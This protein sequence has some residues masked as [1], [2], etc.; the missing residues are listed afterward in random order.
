MGAARRNL[1]ALNFGGVE[2]VQSGGLSTN[3][4]IGGSQ[5][6]YSGGKTQSALVETSFGDQY[7]SGGEADYSILSA[8]GSQYV[9]S[10]GL[11]YGTDVDSGGSQVISSGGSSDFGAVSA[12]GDQDNYGSAYGVQIYGSGITEVGAVDNFTTIGG[13]GAQY[14]YGSSYYAT[15]G[16]A[17]DQYVESGG[18][19]Y[20]TNIAGDQF[21]NGGVASG[22]QIEFGGRE[23]VEFGGVD[24]ASTIA[25]GGEQ[26]VYSG[27]AAHADAVGSGGEQFDFGLV[28]LSHVSGGLEYVEAGGVDSASTIADGGARPSTRVARRTATLLDLAA[29][30]MSFPAV[31]RREP[32]S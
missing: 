24:S 26:S 30:N 6:I 7:L 23:Y 18:L 20:A 11:A 17:G 14:V 31:T 28:E 5:L 3:A 32:M 25:D 9:Y 15:I 21:V 2:Y 19:A 4:N 13:G 29:R 22:S 27:D 8:G 12:A 16:D 1:R 10:G